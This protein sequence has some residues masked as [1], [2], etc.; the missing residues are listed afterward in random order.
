MLY[1]IVFVLYC[2]MWWRPTAVWRR[3]FFQGKLVQKIGTITSLSQ[4][5]QKLKK[6]FL[7][8]A[9]YKNWSVFSDITLI[10]WTFLSVQLLHTYN[11]KISR[12][13]PIS[14][15]PLVWHLWPPNIHY[16]LSV[17]SISKVLRPK[18]SM[19]AT[20]WL[21]IFTVFKPGISHVR[22]KNATRVS[23]TNRWQRIS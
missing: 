12:L 13:L 23:G 6:K 22:D 14:Y 8:D 11:P 18:P 3:W 2:F 7:I 21:R 10:F 20:R 4:T 1:N 19:Q 5:L 15:W 16:F 17:L 9:H